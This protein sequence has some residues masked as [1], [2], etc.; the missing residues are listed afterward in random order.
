MDPNR[1]QL[2]NISQKSN[3]S[4]KEYAQRRRELVSCMQTPLLESELVNMFMGTL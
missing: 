4:F 1:M 3:E 2:Q